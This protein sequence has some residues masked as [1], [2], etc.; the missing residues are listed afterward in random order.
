MTDVAAPPPFTVVRWREGYSI[1]DVDAFLAEVRPLLQGR[2]PDAELADRIVRSRFQP[3][4]LRPSYDMGGVD[5]RLDVL[6]GLALQG[7]PQR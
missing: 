4:R 3:V 2:L 6:H 7:H 1:P 5:D